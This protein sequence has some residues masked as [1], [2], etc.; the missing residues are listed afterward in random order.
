M[1]LSKDMTIAEVLKGGNVEA[2]AEVLFNFGMHCLGCA[3]AKGETLA[4]AAEVHGV[5]I[6][7]MLKA[8]EDADK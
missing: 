3:L 1:A 7:L 8:L 4:E 6:E 5:D 2:K